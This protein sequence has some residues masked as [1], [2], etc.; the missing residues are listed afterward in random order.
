MFKFNAEHS[1]REALQIALALSASESTRSKVF[2]AADAFIHDP[3]HDPH[4]EH[5]IAVR[6]P[7]GA[8][9]R[10]DGSAIFRL[11]AEVALQGVTHSADR[12]DDL[13]SQLLEIKIKAA[14]DR[15][16]VEGRRCLRDTEEEWRRRFRDTEK[17]NTAEIAA[18]KSD[19]A[20]LKSD[21][22]TLNA[23]I[24][25]LNAEIAALKAAAQ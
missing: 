13:R 20:A 8:R 4:Q 11:G 5:A 9:Q 25:A 15:T 6:P 24:A 7:Q 17:Q 16:V 2:G 14:I 1:D 21:N 3:Q 19:N 10:P 12:M 22:A 18:L 23:E